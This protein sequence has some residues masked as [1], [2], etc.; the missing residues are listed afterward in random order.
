MSGFAGF[1][2]LFYYKFKKNIKDWKKALEIDTQ[3]KLPKFPYLMK[4]P[5]SR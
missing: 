5:V 3:L 4:L 2:R 1:E